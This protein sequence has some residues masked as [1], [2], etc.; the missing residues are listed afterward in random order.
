MAL[1]VSNRLVPVEGELLLRALDLQTA[2]RCHWPG[3][4]QGGDVAVFAQQVIHQQE[5]GERQ[6]VAVARLGALLK[7]AEFVR[8][9][10]SEIGH[11]LPD[12]LFQSGGVCRQ[13]VPVNF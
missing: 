4:R 6:R 13:D 7:F 11:V 2:Q 5:L 9:Q 3:H 8:A 12:R 10:R 1:E